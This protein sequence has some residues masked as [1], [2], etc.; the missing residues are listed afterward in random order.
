M[1]VGT[2]DG[3]EVIAGAKAAVSRDRSNSETAAA[4]VLATAG[5]LVAD[6][7]KTL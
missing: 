1:V 7:S 2:I 4:I 6:S 3:A 5:E